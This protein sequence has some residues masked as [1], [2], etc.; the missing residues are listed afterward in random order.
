MLSKMVFEIHNSSY[1]IMYFR[2]IRLK[3]DC[4][5]ISGAWGLGSDFVVSVNCHHPAL[6]VIE[7]GLAYKAPVIKSGS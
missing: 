5:E 6:H 4:L 7:S 3:I 1:I 2:L